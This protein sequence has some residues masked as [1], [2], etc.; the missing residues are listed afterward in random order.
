MATSLSTSAVAAKA[1]A[2]WPHLPAAPADP[3]DDPLTAWQ[4]WAERIAGT[5]F[6]TARLE[7]VA[8]LVAHAVTRSQ[9]DA[10]GSP[11]GNVTALRTGSLSAS[12][13]AP[14]AAPGSDAELATSRP[15]SAYLALRDS[16]AAI[17]VPRMV[18]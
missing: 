3:A 6:G 14:S 17:A 16:I 15:G 7:A 5:V 12:F 2:L 1:R 13:G 10:G 8:H 18:W 4:P 11:A 9:E